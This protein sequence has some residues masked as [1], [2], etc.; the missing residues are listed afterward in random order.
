MLSVRSELPC[1]LARARHVAAS[2]LLLA[3]AH[4]AQAASFNISFDDPGNQ[5]SVVYAPLTSLTQAASQAWTNYFQTPAGATLDIQIRFDDS[6]ASS[7]A[8]SLVGYLSGSTAEGLNVYEQGAAAKLFRGIDAN[9][10]APDVRIYLNPSFVINRLTF[11]PP[12]EPE[13]NIPRVSVDAYSVLLHEL[14]HAFFFNGWLDPQTGATTGSSVSTFDT[15][16]V[17]D[18]GYLYFTGDLAQRVYGGPVP[19]TR[20]NYVHVG[21]HFGEPGEELVFDLM[22]GVRFDRGHRYD[23]SALSLAIAADSGLPLSAEG[24]AL[25]VPEQ[26]TAPY[27]LLGL[28][29]LAWAR[30]RHLRKFKIPG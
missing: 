20:G 3:G 17:E 14:G 30:R 27:V 25:M 19:L 10:S 2:L 18:S 13:T 26:G 1:L 22:N 28:G 15:H 21:N 5:F 6:V 24:L 16:V 11:V 12:D 7:S 4:Q 8:H 29:V 9:G 23:I